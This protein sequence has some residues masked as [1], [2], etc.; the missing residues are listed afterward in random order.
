MRWERGF[1][2]KGRVDR[3]SVEA[4]S[5]QSD[6][7]AAYILDPPIPIVAFAGFLLAG[8]EIYACNDKCLRDVEL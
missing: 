4:S 7:Q 6:G 2:E 3:N 5:H 8:L 1:A